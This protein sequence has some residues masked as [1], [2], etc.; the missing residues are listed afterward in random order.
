VLFLLGMSCCFAATITL[1]TEDGRKFTTKRL[2]NVPNRLIEG[3]EI[4][5][6]VVVVLGKNSELLYEGTFGI[7]PTP[8]PTPIQVGANVRSVP[9]ELNTSTDYTKLDISV[10]KWNGEQIQSPVQIEIFG[11]ETCPYCVK[12]KKLAI[13]S[14]GPERMKNFDIEKSATAKRSSQEI[15]NAAGSPDYPYVPRISVIDGNYTRWFIGGYDD[16]VRFVASNKSPLAPVSARPDLPQKPQ[17]D[18][19]SQLIVTKLY[20]PGMAI[21]PVQVEIFGTDVDC[22]KCMSAKYQAMET[23]GEDKVKVYDLNE[24]DFYKNKSKAIL[25]TVGLDETYGKPRISIIYYEKNTPRRVFIGGYEDLK[26]FISKR[27]VK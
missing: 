7:V 2:R 19:I 8:T 26:D 6:S 4:K 27:R 25:R 13:R 20:K 15:L 16:L 11:T 14:F 24:S 21:N 22:E 9:T 10:K 3:G 17:S 18:F 12:A 23:F 5:S 1:T